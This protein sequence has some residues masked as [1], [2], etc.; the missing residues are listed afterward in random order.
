MEPASDNLW[1]DASGEMADRIRGYD[2]ASSPLGALASWPQ[3]LK[4]VANLLLAHRFPMAAI[5]GPEHVIFYNDAYRS[6]LND[7]HPSTLGRPMQEHWPE[8][9]PLNKP[10]LHRVWAGETVCIDDALWPKSRFGEPKNAWYTFALSPLRDD[11]GRIAG[12]LLTAFETTTRHLAEQALRRTEVREAFLL[13]LSDT[14][15]ALTDPAAIQMAAARVLGEHLGADYVGYAE[16]HSMTGEAIVIRSYTQQARGLEG[17]YR[18]DDYGSNLL[19]ELRA[20]RMVVRPDIANDPALT[21]MQKAAHAV[22]GLGATVNLPL[23]KSGQLEAVM[24][25]HYR[26]A[27]HFADAELELLQDVAERTWAEVMRARAEMATRES[28]QRFRQFANASS[29]G[30]WIRN[31]QTLAI[32]FV[33]PAIAQIYGVDLESFYADPLVWS[34]LIVPDDRDRA[35]SCLHQMLAGNSLTHE[36]RIQ[37]RCDGSFRWIRSTAFPLLAPDGRVEHIAGISSDITEARQSAEHQAILLAE[38]QHR[39]RNIMAMMRSLVIRTATTAVSK[40]DY[41]QGL[42][43][44]LTT[45][46]RVQALLTRTAS[47]GVSIAA[48]IHDEV[49]AQA[50]HATQVKVSGPDVMLSPKAS[51]VLTLAIH[52][53]ATNALKHGALSAANGSVRV[54]WHTYERRKT[55]WLRLDW[56]ERGNRPPSSPGQRRRGFGTELIECL[57]PYELKGTGQLIVD[58]DGARCTLTFPLAD[59]HSILETRAPERSIVFGGSLDMSDEPDLSGQRVLVLEDDYY[60][61]SDASAALR[62]A[63]AVIVGPYSSERDAAKAAAENVI[64]AAVL[65]I[66][67]DEG[68]SFK[69]AR[70]LQERHVPF[71]FLTGYNAEIIPADL[72]AVERLQKP[73]HLRQIV[74]SIYNVVHS[75]I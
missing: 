2:W 30:L 12:A 3:S 20:G 10:L 16:D 67:T 49:S 13:K 65:D 25:L 73:V 28:E 58:G 53:L 44:R 19:T 60:L 47:Q 18:Y 17:T 24:F 15:R 9:M 72:G 26:H 11:D 52:E 57:I 35:L 56:L 22:L 69:L 59:G 34:A 7:K 1:P 41:A 74:A 5:W 68:P 75:L 37:R 66:N 8:P 38:L 27:H 33:S 31:A 39:V 23:L 4:T 43:G 64:T 46:A 63:G 45:L 61:A 42:E 55:P 62:G 51:E 50:S 29:D 54:K 71:V 32:E 14:L 70:L 6:L 40:E 21:D 48:I 36:F